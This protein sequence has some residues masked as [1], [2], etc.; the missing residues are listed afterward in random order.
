VEERDFIVSMERE[1]MLDCHFEVRPLRV[2]LNNGGKVVAKVESGCD[3]IRLEKKNAAPADDATYCSDGKRKY[4]TTDLVKKTLANST[5]CEVTSNDDNCIWAYIDENTD[6]SKASD[7]FRLGKITFEYYAHTADSNPTITE[8][9]TLAQRYLYPI[10]VTREDGSTYTYYVEYYEEYSPN[11][12]QKL[13]AFL[14]ALSVFIPWLANLS[15]VQQT[16]IDTYMNATAGDTSNS[17]IIL[18]LSFP[19][20]LL[21]LF[22][23]FF[24]YHM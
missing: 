15:F 13:A 8:T 2:K 10:K 9:Y 24:T 14:F 11:S 20:E 23:P 17:S 7:G 16:I 18:L 19:L 21:Y 4:F 6:I 12:K 3:W 1:T 5:K 22:G